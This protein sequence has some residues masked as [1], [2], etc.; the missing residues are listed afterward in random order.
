[1]ARSEQE[2]IPFQVSPLPGGSWLIFVPHPDDEVF[3]MG[4]TLLLARGRGIQV[5][6]V[7][8]TDG[9]LGGSSESGKPLSGIREQ[10]S[11]KTAERIG[12]ESIRFWK[13][14]DRELKV[15]LQL[16]KRVSDLINDIQPASIFFPSPM[17]YHPDHRT[18]A[19]LV[20]EGLQEARFSG[21]ALSYSISSPG[22]INHLIDISSVVKEKNELISFFKSQLKENNYNDVI[23][24]LDR[25]RTY[26]LPKDVIAAEGFFEFQ[27]GNVDLA[28]Q[29]LSALRPYWESHTVSGMPLI[30]VI[31]RTLNRPHLLRIALQSLAEQTYSRIEVIVVN[32]GGENVTKLIDSLGHLFE[33]FHYVVHEETRGRSSAANTGLKKTTGEYIAFLDDDDWLAPGHYRQLA[34]LLQNRANTDVVAAYAGVQSVA[35]N[36]NIEP[37]VFNETFDSDL[38]KLENYIPIHAI[39]FK[40]Q[41]LEK[42]PICRFD[43]DL[44]LFEDWDFLLQMLQHGDFVHLDK[45]TAFYR[46]SDHSGEGVVAQ[47]EERSLLALRQILHKWSPQW[48]IDYLIHLVG[49]A[50]FLGRQVQDIESKREE[51]ANEKQFHHKEIDQLNARSGV[52]ENEIIQTK[53]HYEERIETIQSDYEASNT[54]TIAHYEAR[55]ELN[56]SDY[57]ASNTQT[58]AHYEEEM[59]NI[60]V[61]FNDEISK[62]QDIIA[63]LLGSKSWKL[64][65]PL[66][67]VARLFRRGYIPIY[68]PLKKAVWAIALYLYRSRILSP[69]IRI[70]PFSLKHKLKTILI[71]QDIVYRVPD[72]MIF[73]NRSLKSMPLVSIIIPV[74]NHAE[75]LM[76]CIE[77]ALNQTYQN[78][79]VIIYDD[80][81]TDPEIRKILEKYRE[82]PR[83]TLL[84]G[85]KNYGISSAQN[86]LLLESKG[87]IIAFLDCDDFLDLTAVEK[88]MES[89][90]EETIYL[91]TGRINVDNHNNEVNRISFE[92]LPR[93]DYFAENLDRM[94]ATHFKLVRRDVFAKV[95]LFD[96][97]FD[98][99]QDYDML[100]RIAFHYPSSAF[101]HLPDF[102]YYHRFH[103]SQATEILNS[104]QDQ[105]TTKIQNEARL[106]KSI[107]D[108]DYDTHFI[109]FIMLSYGKKKQTLSA[110]RSLS[111]TVRIPHEIILFDNG[112]SSST[113]EYI[114]K[115]IE[116]QFDF[117]NVIYN[118]TNLGPAAGRREALKH[119]HGDWIVVFDNDEI[120]EP[121]W[122]EELLARASTDPSIGAVCCKVIFPDQSLHFSGGYFDHED[123]QLINLKLYDRGKNVFDLSSAQLRDCDWCPIGA[124]LFTLNPLHYLH[125]GYPNI[126]EDVGV[127]MA[128]RRENR[129]LVNAPA[130]WVWH[131]HIT[132]QSEKDDMHESYMQDRYN[133]KLMMTSLRSFFRENGLIIKDEYVWREN[134]LDRLSRA[135]LVALLENEHDIV[136]EAQQKP[137]S[138]SKGSRKNKFTF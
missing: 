61:E 65:R 28:T 23:N 69:I 102:L 50:R 114:K 77:S 8:L 39:L 110:I 60:N 97:R 91:H 17:E 75:F 125:E 57:E 34:G 31:V 44:N 72:E 67:F 62:L 59:G 115:N 55:I 104:H 128:L 123:E 16:K 27:T 118:D 74:Y 138:L 47:N 129:R 82:D 81:S 18:A 48:G 134:G 4:G 88:C 108:G 66:R 49:R 101:Y 98:S 79:E 63:R 53:H 124:T 51:L 35:I 136:H 78:I 121:G 10:E 24:A 96:P 89:W 113:V 80:A 11:R 130:S 7:I 94:F 122:L 100:M 33:K 54:Q 52:L 1:M 132:Y 9:A 92:Q 15:T 117:L 5:H 103:D 56:K 40:R 131:D 112:S 105:S 127:S 133:P 19:E 36:K 46:V 71:P 30:S 32:D 41:V 29:V 93:K 86:V 126:F 38:L 68:L 6:L 107:R 76:Q 84:F 120:A 70:I 58:I 119:A 21:R 135:D 3:G 2:F 43:T 109:S 45:I 14:P 25:S 106:R 95:G 99:A 13:I 87:D 37:K 116:N 64:T 42:D 22:R 137:D 12:V 90:Q 73:K 111:E 83:S 85:E 20:W 26:T